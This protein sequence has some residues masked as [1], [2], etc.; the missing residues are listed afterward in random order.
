MGMSGQSVSRA[1]VAAGAVVV[2][3]AIVAAAQIVRVVTLPRDGRL[4][5]SFELTG[6]Y[7]PDIRE[8]ILTGLQTTFSYDVKLRRTAVFWFESHGRF[9]VGSGPCP[10]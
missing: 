2:L 3:G 8:V 9:G 4:L 7:T 5:V 6:A 10:V 1:A